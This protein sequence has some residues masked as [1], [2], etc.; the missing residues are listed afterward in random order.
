[1]TQKNL[2][3]IKMFSALA[4]SSSA[5]FLVSCDDDFDNPADDLRENFLGLE[6]VGFT[7]EQ[8]ASNAIVDMPIAF[9]LGDTIRFD[10]DIYDDGVLEYE[11][12]APTQIVIEETNRDSA[13][14][15]LSVPQLY[16]RDVLNNHEA[17]L[18]ETETFV[19][20]EA[21]VQALVDEAVSN[22]AGATSGLAE[23]LEI[24]EDFDPNLS[25]VDLN[26]NT[27][28]SLAGALRAAGFVAVFQDLAVNDPD[29][30]TLFSSGTGVYVRSF[31]QTTLDTTFPFATL[32]TGGVVVIGVEE[33]PETTTFADIRA[34]LAAGVAPTITGEALN[35]EIWH[36][37]VFV[38]GDTHFGVAYARANGTVINYGTTESSN[39]TIT[40]NSLSN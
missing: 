4:I 39:F 15:Q 34:D 2:H 9:G 27:L 11:F 22:S 36:E 17:R 21:D 6:V 32:A 38:P 12:I 3:C 29:V 14:L 19:T 1:M 30:V 24:P 26:D 28:Q 23:G 8:L 13:L 18:N 10:G 40:L 31:N 5:L 33:L 37:L 7:P 35:T 25:F 16:E 20:L